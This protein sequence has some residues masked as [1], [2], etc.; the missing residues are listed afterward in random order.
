MVT[1]GKTKYLDQVTKQYITGI[2]SN[3][4]VYVF[5]TGFLLCFYF[6]RYNGSMKTA[7]NGG[8][9]AL[10]KCPLKLEIRL[11]V[12]DVLGELYSHPFYENVSEFK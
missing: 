2:K 9:G 7:K 8:L 3:P 12:T 6:V 5:S 4:V 10:D 11:V 1:I